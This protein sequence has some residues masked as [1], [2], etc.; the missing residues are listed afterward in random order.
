MGVFIDKGRLKKTLKNMPKYIGCKHAII[1]CW[2]IFFKTSLYTLGNE[3]L[4]QRRKTK[5]S[6]KASQNKLYNDNKINL[7]NK[8]LLEREISLQNREKQIGGTK[9]PFLLFH[10]SWN[11]IK[12]TAAYYI[13]PESN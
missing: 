5:K 13:S 2:A 10:Q 1:A 12:T 7:I 8:A 3:Q 6:M 4:L 11:E 9:F